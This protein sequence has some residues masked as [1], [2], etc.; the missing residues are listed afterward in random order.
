MI[1]TFALLLNMTLMFVHDE[2]ILLR[3]Y[4]R[5]HFDEKAYSQVHFVSHILVNAI[6]NIGGW[7]SLNFPN[8]S[9]LL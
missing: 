8:Q 5:R 2:N 7:A 1:V 9:C 4:H 3:K 6:Q